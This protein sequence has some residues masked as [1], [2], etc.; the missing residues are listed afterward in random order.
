[1][2]NIA[3]SVYSYTYLDGKKVGKSTCH[4]GALV[5]FHEDQ[6]DHAFYTSSNRGRYPNKKDI[7]DRERI[8]R[9]RWIKPVIEGSVTKTICYKVVDYESKRERRLYVV[10]ERMYVVWLEARSDEGW[11]FSTAYVATAEDLRRYC[12][13]QKK[14][15]VAP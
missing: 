14:E 5:L 8:K 10:P 13:G 9:M 12:K 1:M 3:R 4:D 7:I 6:F 11:K 2:K 15:W